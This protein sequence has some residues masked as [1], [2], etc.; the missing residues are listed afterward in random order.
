MNS[1]VKFSAVASCAHAAYARE[2]KTSG[3]PQGGIALAI[4]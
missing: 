2:G 4:S 1:V 3:P